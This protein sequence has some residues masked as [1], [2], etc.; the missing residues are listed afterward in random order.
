[1]K[2]LMLNWILSLLVFGVQFKLLAISNET[3][4][5]GYCASSTECSE[6]SLKK[7]NESFFFKLMSFFSAWYDKKI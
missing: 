7:Y 5:A 6:H 3:R 2:H 1:M 4:I